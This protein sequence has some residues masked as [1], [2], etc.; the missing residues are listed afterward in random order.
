MS[1]CGTDIH[2]DVEIKGL[3]SYKHLGKAGKVYLGASATTHVRKSM[4]VEGL[5]PS[6]LGM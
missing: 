3:G 5:E 1:V 4:S 6:T 2:K